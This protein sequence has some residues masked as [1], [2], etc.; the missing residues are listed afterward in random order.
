MNEIWQDF[1]K[2]NPELS[3]VWDVLL[4]KQLPVTE[5]FTALSQDQLREI[6]SLTA[7]LRKT[8]RSR[9]PMALLGVEQITG[10]LLGGQPV[11]QD[12]YFCGSTERERGPAEPPE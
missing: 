10:S 2:R 9:V 3:W 8:D 1:I 5:R 6:Q 12:K 4:G 7:K 11:K